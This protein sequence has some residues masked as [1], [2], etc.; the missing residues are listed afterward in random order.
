MILARSSERVITTVEKQGPTASVRLP[1]WLWMRARF[2]SAN[3]PV[4]KDGNS[5][6]KLLSSIFLLN[7]SNDLLN[8]IWCL[9][10][11]VSISW[12]PRKLRAARKALKKIL[13]DIISA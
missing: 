10:S 4:N 11:R 7:D 12:I 3:V 1:I 9:F 6:G 13:V 5:T 2:H 8:A